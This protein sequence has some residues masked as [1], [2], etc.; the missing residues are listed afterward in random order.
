[1]PAGHGDGLRSSPTKDAS[2]VKPSS[3][4][5]PSCVLSTPAGSRHATAASGVLALAMATLRPRKV[6]AS[7]LSTAPAA[8]PDRTFGNLLVPESHIPATS[9]PSA[10]LQFPGAVRRPGGTLKT[11]RARKLAAMPAR[12]PSSCPATGE[13]TGRRSADAG[14]SSCRFVLLA[15]SAVGPAPGWLGGRD[16]PPWA[17]DLRAIERGRVLLTV[18][19]VAPN[20]ASGSAT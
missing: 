19:P 3:G 15:E 11:R 17:H 8:A 5:P 6:A 16:R 10:T 4:S 18:T 1:V 7:R 14:P 9:L 13:V 12:T 2:T 20:G